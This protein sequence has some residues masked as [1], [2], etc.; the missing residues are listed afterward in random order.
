MRGIEKQINIVDRWSVYGDAVERPHYRVTFEN[1]PEGEGRSHED[2]LRVPGAHHL[3]VFPRMGQL[4]GPRDF[5]MCKLQRSHANQDAA[6]AHVGRAT[7][8][9]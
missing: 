1:P 7:A 4:S 9:A 5:Q 8:N 3:S 2:V 6:V